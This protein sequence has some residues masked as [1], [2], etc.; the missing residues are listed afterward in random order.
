MVY[1]P[2]EL[3]E[4]ARVTEILVITSSEQQPIFNKYLGY[5]F[6]IGINL[7]YAIQKAPMV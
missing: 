1:Y 2:V 7:S 6:Q 4:K 3:F 5:G